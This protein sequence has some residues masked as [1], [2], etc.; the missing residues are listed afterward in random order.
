MSLFE[1]KRYDEE[2][3]TSDGYDHLS[4]LLKKIEERK[5]QRIDKNESDK[6]E[7]EKPKKKRK[8]KSKKIIADGENDVSE[9]NDGEVE[10]DV[11]GTNNVT[12]DNN[13]E[14][15]GKNE[16]DNQDFMILGV[17]N[18]KKKTKV[19]RVLPKWLTHPEVISADLT[20]GPELDEECRDLLKLDEQL[21]EALK[22]NGIKKLFPEKL[23]LIQQLKNNL[24]RQVRCLIVLPVQELAAQVNRVM[25]TYCKNTNLKVA[26]ITGAA[27]M[28]IEQLKLVKKTQNGDLISK[29]DIVISTPGRLVDHIE[30]TQGFTLKYLE[31][32]I[33][34]EADRSTDWLKYIPH[35]H[36]NIPSLTIKNL[37]SYSIP[38][39]QNATLSQDPEKLSR[40]NLFQP[41]LFTSAMLKNHDN[42]EDIDLDKCGEFLGKY[43]SPVE[44]TERAFECS[45][46]YKPVAAL[47]LVTAGEKSEKTLIFT[48]S[49]KSAHRLALLLGLMLKDRN[50]PVDELSAQM[51]PKQRNEV[52]E[53]F[54]KAETGVLVNSDALARGVDI[55]DVTLVISYDLPKYIK[56]YIHRSGRTGRAGKLG[57]AI[58]ILTNNQISAFNR[59]LASARKVV[60]TI[61]TFDSLETVAEEINYADK[62]T[63]LGKIIS[64]E[65][66]KSNSNNNNTNSNNNNKSADK[67]GKKR[68]AGD[69]NNSKKD[70]RQRKESN[71][72]AD[73]KCWE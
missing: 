48:N 31:F 13:K 39:A 11:S 50:I 8:K 17:N 70:K 69:D 10:K 35:P 55:P 67:K 44:L 49:G 5:K 73:F 68:V 22:D 21:V 33:I 64:K 45:A 53:K 19:T 60:P 62:L 66:V 23:W 59:M 18:S 41:I 38:P 6:I 32:L 3:E 30:K 51:M 58:S 25:L 56:G 7:E 4:E 43:T 26:L 2:L 36:Y 42:D 1:I 47:K 27:P 52:L 15:S 20:S 72:I 29:V 28:E 40:L 37:Q 12:E 34:D 57:T 65:E 63:E 71:Q 9:K 16:D 61:E 54:S 46:A 14:E 24:I